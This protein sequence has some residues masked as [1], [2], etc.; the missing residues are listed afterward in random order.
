MTFDAT[1]KVEHILERRNLFPELADL[2]C[3]FVVSAVESL[4]EDVL[5]H[6][7][8]GHTRRML[9]RL[10]PFS[11]AP[12]FPCDQLWLP[13]LPGLPRE[14]TWSMLS[15]VAEH[16]L[17]EHIDPIQYSI[18][19]LI[20]PGSA[21][22]DGEPGRRCLGTWLGDLDEAAFT[23]R[24]QHPD[25][26]WM[27]CS[28]KFLLWWKSPC[29]STGPTYNLPGDLHPG[30]GPPGR[31]RAH[32]GGQQECLFTRIARRAALQCRT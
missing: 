15:F 4:S 23:Y 6:L 26:A 29:V 18:R 13:S 24:W 14:I 16:D 7:K 25:D 28:A 9:S 3:V 11:T 30:G 10:S 8:K 31:S 32:A 2:G 20:P 1:I 12:V 17:V 27:D 21:L 19:L 5:R 22:L